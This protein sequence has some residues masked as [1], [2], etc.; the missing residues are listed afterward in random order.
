MVHHSY[1]KM[2]VCVCVCMCTHQQME[3]PLKT[4]NSLTIEQRSILTMTVAALI[5]SNTAKVQL[6]S[7]LNGLNQIKNLFWIY[8]YV[9]CMC[10]LYTHGV[11]V[12]CRM[13]NARVCCLYCV[14]LF[15]WFTIILYECVWM[16]KFLCVHWM[17]PQPHK[18][19]CW[20][21]H[22]Y[23]LMNIRLKSAS[24]PWNDGLTQQN[25]ISLAVFKCMRM[26]Y[27]SLIWN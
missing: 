22:E 15:T 9:F 27:T 18:I 17:G 12:S 7:H 13:N 23:Q 25:N 20:S 24:I 1:H 3:Q 4:W 10:V 21:N 6:Y 14:F 26:S 2:N 16:Y 5:H 11:S 8:L 19:W